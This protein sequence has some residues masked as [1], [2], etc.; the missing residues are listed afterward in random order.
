[1]GRVSSMREDFKRPPSDILEAADFIV[2]GG[3][4]G[5][6]TETVYGLAADATNIRRKRKAIYRPIDCP[7]M[8][9]AHG[10]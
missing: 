5:V 6:P 1:M 8:R 9:H 4:G 2:R 10:A 7:C 3:I